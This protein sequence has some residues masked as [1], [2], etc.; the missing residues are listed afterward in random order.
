MIGDFGL[1]KMM[2]DANTHGVDIDNAIILP[3]GYTN[4]MHTAGVGTA[5]YASPE[6]ITT[7]TYSTAADIFSLGLIL[8]ELFSNFT[9]EHER[10]KAFH[11][12]RHSSE[13]APW[14]KRYYPEVS[15]LIV[16]CTQADWSRR[17]SASDIQ[18]AGM[19]QE[20]GKGA[21]IFRAEL[22]SM[23]VEMAR[24]DDQIQNQ[25]E[26]LIEKD[27]L[28]QSQTEQLIEKD[29]MIEDMRRRLAATA[30]ARHVCYEGRTDAVKDQVGDDIDESSGCSSSDADY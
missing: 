5:S 28:I 6:Q 23:K 2:K 14:M 18:A 24:K 12:C 21:E 20:I 1:S 29:A 8:L 27:K 15:A 9:S 3:K 25:T 30:E 16:A 10:A 4:G 7:K 13:L 17:P 26:Q 11:D 19:F 22:I